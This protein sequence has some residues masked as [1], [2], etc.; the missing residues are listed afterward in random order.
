M[1]WSVTTE[2]RRDGCVWHKARV[3]GRLSLDQTYELHRWLTDHIGPAQFPSNQGWHPSLDGHSC[4]Y[5]AEETDRTLFLLS[6]A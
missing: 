1:N 4:F 6:W 3:V 5:F 2:R